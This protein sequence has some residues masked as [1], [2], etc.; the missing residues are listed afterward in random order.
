MENSVMFG[1]LALVRDEKN[2][3]LFFFFFLLII[4]ENSSVGIGIGEDSIQ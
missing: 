2:E 1:H 4:F 3:G